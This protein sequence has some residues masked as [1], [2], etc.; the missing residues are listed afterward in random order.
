MQ[1]SNSMNSAW[2]QRVVIIA[3]IGVLLV[4]AAILGYQLS[5]GT[6]GSSLLASNPVPP[7]LDRVRPPR[8]GPGGGM[9]RASLLASNPVPPPLDRVRPPRIGPGGDKLV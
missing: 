3:V 2:A 8:I 1:A 5:G 6:G 4:V 9:G 7:P